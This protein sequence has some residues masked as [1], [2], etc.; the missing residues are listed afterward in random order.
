MKTFSRS[1]GFLHILVLLFSPNV[2]EH[3]IW[4]HVV[5]KGDTVV[6]A[7]CGNGYD[8]L[9]ML[10]MAS[11]AFNLGYLPG[12]DKTLITKSDTTRLAMEVASRIVASGGLISMLV[13]VGH[14]GGM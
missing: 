2:C 4:N 13:Y 10:N 11:C 6:D 5:K 3:E 12:G 14:P 1:Y 9:A 7:T 8:T